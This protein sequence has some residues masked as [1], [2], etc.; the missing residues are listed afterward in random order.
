V[1]EPAKT[2]SRDTKKP[3]K[4]AQNPPKDEKQTKG[5]SKPKEKQAFFRKLFS[6]A[7]KEG[8]RIGLQPLPALPGKAKKP[9]G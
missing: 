8:K 9:R 2:A 5:S 6:R 3:I 4:T 1:S 7:I